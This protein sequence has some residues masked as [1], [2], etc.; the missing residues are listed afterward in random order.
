MVPPLDTRASMSVLDQIVEGSL[1]NA[2]T[3]SMHLAYIIRLTFY[4]HTTAH[5]HK[6]PPQELPYPQPITLTLTLTLTNQHYNTKKTLTS[7]WM[8]VLYSSK[9]SISSSPWLFWWYIGTNWETAVLLVSGFMAWNRP[10]ALSKVSQRT[11]FL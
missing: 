5:I 3:N 7:L 11:T 10:E 6:Y 2:H 1:Q 8:H 9:L 4:T